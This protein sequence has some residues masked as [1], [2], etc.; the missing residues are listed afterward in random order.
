MQVV[1]HHEVQ[2]LPKIFANLI[3]ELRERD[4]ARDQTLTRFGHLELPQ[5]TVGVPD[6]EPRD[7]L[8]DAQLLLGQY[9]P[10]LA[11]RDGCSLQIPYFYWS[12]NP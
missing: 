2:K 9:S 6:Y 12:G 1:F 7:D 5:P 10:F 8:L 11:P 4:L 3:Y